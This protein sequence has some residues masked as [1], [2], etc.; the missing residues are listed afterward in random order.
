M[1]FS[2]IKVD[3]DNPSW[4]FQTV[5]NRFP[6]GGISKQENESPNNLLLNAPSKIMKNSESRRKREVYIEGKT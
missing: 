6:N 1:K 3:D 5:T 4:S 2:E